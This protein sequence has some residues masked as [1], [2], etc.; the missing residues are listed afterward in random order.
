MTLSAIGH[1]A[2]NN[3]HTRRRHL[4]FEL[5][6]ESAHVIYSDAQL[7]GYFFSFASPA[8]SSARPQYASP[9]TIP[10]SAMRV[11]DDDR[12]TSLAH[13]LEPFAIDRPL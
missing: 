5:P 4:P 12:P 3:N 13:F 8:L 9:S 7:K 1:V 2:L 10:S 6:T 11:A